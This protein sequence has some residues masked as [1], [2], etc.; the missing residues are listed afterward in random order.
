M[1]ACTQVAIDETPSV[2]KKHYRR[3]VMGD[4]EFDLLNGALLSQ[5][6]LPL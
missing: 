6:C 4:V 5:R 2:S 1:M 3:I